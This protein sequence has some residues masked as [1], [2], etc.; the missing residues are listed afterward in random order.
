MQ[1]GKEIQLRLFTTGRP[2][3]SAIGKDLSGDYELRL[4]SKKI[5][6]LSSGERGTA[7]R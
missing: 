3:T 1:Q 6:M 4:G 7:R 2:L 5:D